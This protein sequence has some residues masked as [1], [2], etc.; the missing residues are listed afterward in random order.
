M[1]SNPRWTNYT[2]ALMTLLAVKRRPPT[3]STLRAVIEEGL[4]TVDFYPLPPKVEPQRVRD[5][6]LRCDE[7]LRQAGINIICR[8]THNPMGFIFAGSV[9]QAQQEVAKLLARLAT[10]T[11]WVG[12]YE[13]R[14]MPG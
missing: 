1:A 11:I 14:G 5:E 13:R 10:T 12:G 8:M 4:S 3:I 6:L 7:A 9:K 2:D